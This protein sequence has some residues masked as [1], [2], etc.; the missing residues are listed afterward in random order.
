MQKSLITITC[1]LLFETGFYIARA[2]M[3]DHL[4][5]QI[6]GF[7]ILRSISESKRAHV[8]LAEQ[9]SLQ[10]LVALKVL[11]GEVSDNEAS[12]KRVI[13]DGKAAARLTHPNLLS[14]FDIG[15]AD[16][17]Y[18]I[19]TEY[20]QGG[21]LRERMSAAN[22]IG[23]N[24][25]LLLA[26]DLATGLKFLHAQGFLHRDIKPTNVFFREDGTAL[27]GE[28]GVA[29]AVSGK[30]P[31]NEQVAFGSPHYMS[32][33]RAQALPSDAR[34]DQYSLGV[35]LWEA[36]TGK[37]PFDDEDA[38]Q[39][40][41]KHITEPVPALP[42]N[43]AFLQ[44]VLGK[45]LAKQPEQRFTSA[46]E[47]LAALDSVIQERGVQAGPFSRPAAPV[48]T[49]APTTVP[50]PEATRVQA[51]FDMNASDTRPFDPV[52]EPNSGRN[53]PN[54][55]GHATTVL[56][57]LPAQA[58]VL[59]MPNTGEATAVVPPIRSQ[60]PPVPPATM[61]GT[62]PVM[63]VAP[64]ATPPPT[65]AMTRPI[66]PVAPP[67]APLPPL[68][69]TA[70]SQ[71]FVPPPASVAPPAAAP[72]PLPASAFQVP[73][74]PI[75]PP[76]PGAA[77]KSS[78]AAGWLIWLGVLGLLCAA[79]AAW[80]ILKGSKDQAP[81][82]APSTGNQ[83]SSANDTTSEAITSTT[84]E[85]PAPAP[86]QAA[87]APST[88]VSASS[89]VLPAADE[90]TILLERAK[91]AL[92]QNEL[93]NPEDQCAAYYYQQALKL[94]PEN[95]DAQ[96][97]MDNTQQSIIEAINMM[98]ADGKATK[99]KLYLESAMKFFPDSQPLK[100]LQSQLQG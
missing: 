38:F 4:N 78:S 35:V 44:P 51:P 45:C 66:Q 5:P 13:E 30:T 100:D 69:A 59:S 89:P 67:A 84:S 43:L 85:T 28:A 98:T 17:R 8:Y 82:E 39:V 33:E 27:L 47:L 32:P 77:K 1:G 50:V 88:D 55:G 65:M 80:W 71:P 75:A 74:V 87:A 63:P 99:A 95:A 86:T 29:R 64:P 36:L 73:N 10:R 31:E 48:A 3:T 24:G 93:V 62:R 9:T 94:D 7:R 34:S 57:P 20:V 83:T 41:I 56:P 92:A 15:E 76:Q 12:R 58:P 49:V 81:R 42:L 18:F 53:L 90:I 25:A 6:P 16:G 54:D 72:A 14:V 70:V 96:I 26:R 21:T 40:A 52:P 23:L 11:S 68:G 97:G 2:S 22:G 91:T 61:V 79:G 19:A 37:P 46:A 60:A